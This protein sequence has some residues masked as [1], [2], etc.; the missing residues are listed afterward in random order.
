MKNSE[1]DEDFIEKWLSKFL[2]DIDRASLCEYVEGRNI[3]LE[4][5]L[6]HD[7]KQ[8]LQEERKA[9]SR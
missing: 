7:I 3:I 1:L 9:N 5:Y 8:L 4:E 2:E 6:S